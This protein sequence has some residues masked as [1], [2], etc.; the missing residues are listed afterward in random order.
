MMNQ[1]H[2]QTGLMNFICCH[3]WERRTK[4]RNVHTNKAPEDSKN[5]MRLITISHDDGSQA[6]PKF[7]T[8]CFFD[9]CVNSHQT[10]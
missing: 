2:I 3:A 8:H 1:K 6:V 5:A 10:I 4:V 9:H 7:C